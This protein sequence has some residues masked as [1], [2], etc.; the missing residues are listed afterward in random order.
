[1]VEGLLE[2]AP[3]KSSRARYDELVRQISLSRTTD[4]QARYATLVVPKHT[5]HH[6]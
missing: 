1:M 5:I 6:A 2:A 3:V 4:N